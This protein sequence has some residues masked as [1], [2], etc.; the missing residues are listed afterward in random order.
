MM[1]T[2]SPDQESQ[3]LNIRLYL[4]IAFCASGFSALIYEVV[5]ARMLA[6]TFGSTMPAISMV[7]ATFMGGLAIGSLLFGRF[8]DRS[9][10]PLRLFSLLELTIAIFALIFPYALQLVTTL[11]VAG[12]QAAAYQEGLLTSLR[13]IFSSILLLPPAIC[14]GG[15]FPVLGRYFANSG[16]SGTVGRLYAVNTLGA[17]SGALASAFLLLPNLGHQSTILVA[18]TVNISTAA[19]AFALA[20][21]RRIQ[22]PPIP[23]Q[24][25]LRAC[26]P[27]KWYL[28]FATFGIGACAL[29]YEILWT[30][31][32][33]LFLGS[34]VF[35]FASI[36]GAFLIG[37]TLGGSLGAAIVRK[38]REVPSIFM[39]LT[40]TMGLSVAA[41]F[42]FYDRL[43]YLYHTAHLLAEGQWWLLAL[44]SFAITA[45][46]ILLPATLSGALLPI[47]VFLLDEDAKQP[48]TTI[49]WTVLANSA[50]AIVGSLSA[51]FLLIPFFGLQG[52]FRAVAALN[53]LF[54]AALLCRISISSRLRQLVFGIVVIGFIVITIPL[55]WR[56]EL[57]NAGVYVYPRIIE[58]Q[59]GL[60]AYTSKFQLLEVF[61]GR[62]ATVAIKESPDGIRSLS[63]N[64]K[65]D[66]SSGRDL[67]TQLLL[68]HLPLLLHSNPRTAMVIGLGSGI[69]LGAAATYPLE[70]LTAVEISNEVID[71][72]RFFAEENGRVLNDD[73]LTLL[74]DDAR[75]HLLT[76]TAT[77]D[78][79]TSEPSNPWQKG[80]ANLFTHEFYQLTI[81]RLKE[82]GIFCQWVPLYDISPQ[83]LEVINQTFLRSFPHA[84]AFLSADGYDLLL[85][86][87]KHEIVFDYRKIQQ[88]LARQSVNNSLQLIG[89]ESPGSLIARNYLFS[90][91][92]LRR[93]AGDAPI[94]TDANQLLEFSYP[95]IFKDNLTANHTLFNQHFGQEKIPLTNPGGTD[96]EKISALTDLTDAYEQAGKTELAHYFRQIM[97]RFIGD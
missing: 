75:N 52:S 18:V 69:T 97:Q 39:V 86:G 1:Q 87:S 79:I 54:G 46:P 7:T 23:S 61:E 26:I 33:Q 91:V 3:P 73:R 65:F 11:Y 30:R 41:T 19:L 20:S 55:P 56:Q 29:A 31:T 24:P 42:P 64:G 13:L 82:Q 49:G 89:I 8:A 28:L 44:L 12:S 92:P 25:R 27:G 93:I 35:A 5:W 4:Y 76:H 9:S 50:G 88:H 85:L 71:A 45:I 10:S 67:E 90:D 16:G 59:G 70:A 80:N 84:L 43:A 40:L 58:R 77:Y 34:T 63:V 60:D 68:G 72:S 37:L 53:L 21:R 2:L 62:D 48:G 51:G 17:T 74:R 94:N 22:P 32:L 15:T 6:L 81:S 66:A 38:T 83:N 95:D 36:L 47:V 14:M 96:R 57:L 78:V